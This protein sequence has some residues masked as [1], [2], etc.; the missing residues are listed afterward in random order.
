MTIEQNLLVHIKDS[1]LCLFFFHGIN[2]YTLCISLI[3]CF[4]SCVNIFCFYFL[5]LFTFSRFDGVLL[6]VTDWLPDVWKHI[7][8]FLE[9]VVSPQVVLGETKHCKTDLYC[10]DDL[11]GH[12][13]KQIKRQQLTC[14]CYLS[15]GII[16]AIKE[17]RTCIIQL[18]RC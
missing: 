18:Q 14:L 16:R 11:S 10:F 5:L 12:T 3:S 8:N 2:I 13:C 1:A 6:H 17:G 9:S 15:L 7:N 4:T